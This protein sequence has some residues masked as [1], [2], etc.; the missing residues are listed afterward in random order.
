MAHDIHAIVRRT[1]VHNDQLNVLIR[2][3]KHTLDALHQVLR[4]VV[5]DDEDREFR[6]DHNN[7]FFSYAF[8]AHAQFLLHE[9]GNNLQL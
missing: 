2:L 1:V 8:H 4:V 9:T 6:H 7:A 3:V 5:V